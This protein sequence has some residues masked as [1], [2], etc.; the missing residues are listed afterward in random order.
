MGSGGALGTRSG[1]RRVPALSTGRPR[2]GWQRGTRRRDRWHRRLSLSRRSAW[3]GPCTLGM[4]RPRSSMARPRTSIALFLAATGLVAG[5]A[6]GCSKAPDADESPT[7][8]AGQ[9]AG[10]GGAVKYHDEGGEGGEGGEG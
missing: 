7:P 1:R 3:A 2:L 8:A 9:P 4:T 10:G 6:A 5:M